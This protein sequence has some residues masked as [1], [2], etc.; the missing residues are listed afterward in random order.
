MRYFQK[1]IRRAQID[2][3]YS[4]G[5]NPHQIMS[6]SAPLG[7]GLTSDG[8]YMDL[9]I[10]SMSTKEAMIELL[11]QQMNEGFLI[12]GFEVLKERLLNQKKETAMALV[13][14]ADYRVSLK[15]G[16][17]FLN[18]STFVESFTNFYQ[19]DS[20][21]I[22]KKT[23][24][25]EKEMDIKPY[26]YDIWFDER[27]TDSEGLAHCDRYD[28]GIAVGLQLATGS[29]INIKP[30]LVME[31]FCAFIGKEFNPYAFQLHRMETYGNIA[32]TGMSMEEMIAAV[33]SKKEIKRELAPLNKIGTVE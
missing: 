25:S 24:K 17:D 19:Q 15:D 1:A 20:I 14:A 21:V 31:A 4:A 12:T 32:D 27:L 6:F 16:Y 13:A 26:L 23:K 33:A 9:E 28:N 10:N 2:V 29:V 11:N 8:E 7:V 18:Q 22:R 3:A 30:D 5:F